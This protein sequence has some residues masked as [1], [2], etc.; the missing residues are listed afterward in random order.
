MP[1]GTTSPASTPTVLETGD[2]T[3]PAYIDAVPTGPN[4]GIVAINAPEEGCLPVAYTIT[5]SPI[6]GPE[7]FEFIF[8]VAATEPLGSPTVATLDLTPGTLYNI[9]TQGT[10]DTGITTPVSKSAVLISPAATESPPPPNSPPPPPPK[11]PP[12][13]PAGGQQG[14]MWGDPHFIGFDRSKFDYHGIV[15]QWYTLLKDGSDLDVKT[16]FEK[17]KG[18]KPNTTVAYQIKVTS[19]KDTV[20]V[21]LMRYPEATYGKRKLDVYIGNATTP[22]TVTRQVEQIELSSSMSLEM[23]YYKSPP[24]Y[25]LIKTPTMDTMV[26]LNSHT[27]RTTKGLNVYLTTKGLLKAPVVGLLGKTYTRALK[28]TVG[29]RS[30]VIQLVASFD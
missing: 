10:C 14:Q 12:P 21:K 22:V 18:I 25:V 23:G 6:S 28:N 17:I 5:M 3:Y 2:V 1:S 27:R 7:T 4:S 15:N 8:T 13:P 9:T 26:T 29:P 19:G 11:S 20:R 16:M 30:S 24:A